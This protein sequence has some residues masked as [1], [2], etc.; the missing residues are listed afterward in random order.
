MRPTT[1]H[2]AIAHLS[3][4]FEI[5]RPPRLKPIRVDGSIRAQPEPDNGW[6]P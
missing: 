2:V 4:Y 5:P 6:N 3:P 1:I